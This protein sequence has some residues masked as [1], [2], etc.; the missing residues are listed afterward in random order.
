MLALVLVVTAFA[1]AFA[2]DVGIEQCFVDK[3]NGERGAVGADPLS[4]DSDVGSYARS[5]AQSMALAGTLFHSS[6]SRLNE[7]LPDG[8]RSWG[9]NVGMA[10]GSDVCARLHEAFMGSPGHRANLLNSAF[11]SV[12]V[13]V[14]VDAAGVT[15]TTHVFYEGSAKPAGLPPFNDDDGSVHEGDIIRLAEAGITKGCGPGRFCPDQP[16]TRG[17]MAAFLKRALG[18]PSTS[19]DYFADDEGHVFEADINVLA[20]GG[21]TSGCTTGAFCPDRTVS[22]GEMAAFLARALQLPVANHD[23]FADDDGSVF[24]GAINSLAAA[25]ITAG[26]RPDT[27]CPDDPVSRAQMASFLVRAFF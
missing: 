13:G 3:I 10:S 7:V 8:W 25:G 27:Y 5:H 17:E 15:W 6:P 19:T 21:I 9:E 14:F 12:G 18:L 23:Y 11:D 26:C 22:R 2:A 24:E 20:A 16:V 4:V 1:P